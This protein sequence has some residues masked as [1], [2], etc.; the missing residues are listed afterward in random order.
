VVLSK[1][2]AAALLACCIAVVLSI[3]TLYFLT[4]MPTARQSLEGVGLFWTVL[5]PML[6][7]GNA[8]SVSMARRQAG[9]SLADAAEAI[10]TVTILGAA[11]LPLLILSTLPG[12]WWAI[13][14][15]VLAMGVLWFFI[16]VPTTV[17]AI[18]RHKTRLSLTA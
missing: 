4:E 5:F 10:I 18:E 16:S 15:Y 7:A 3:P 12:H 9:V 11:S 14:L 1:N 8:R 2:C 13:T 17:R 6:M